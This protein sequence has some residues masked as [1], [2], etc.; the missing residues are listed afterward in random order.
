[1]SRL[2]L[3]RASFAS[4]S[5]GGEAPTTSRP[6]AAS[7]S[8]LAVGMLLAGE[9]HDVR[10]VSEEK[11]RRTADMTACGIPVEVKAFDTFQQ[12]RG[13]PPRAEHVANKLLD[14]RGQGAIAV[15]WGRASGLTEAAARAGYDLFCSQCARSGLGRIRSVRLLGRGFDISFRPAAEAPRRTVGPARA[16]QPETSPTEVG[17]RHVRP[18][19]RRP[20]AGGEPPKAAHR[21]PR[22]AL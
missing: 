14:A 18:G 13:R 1:M 4:I 2:S 22:L 20:H 3:L 7:H 17:P 5:S 10:T 9:G 19:E 8:E 12:R 11:G 15:I 16:G 21:G 6:G